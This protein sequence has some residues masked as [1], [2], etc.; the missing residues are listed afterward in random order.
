V[1]VPLET[2]HVTAAGVITE[3][4]LVLT[5]VHTDSGAVGHSIVVAA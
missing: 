5:D 3:S 4:P 2:P 1:R